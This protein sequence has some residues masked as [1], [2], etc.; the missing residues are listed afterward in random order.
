MKKNKKRIIIYTTRDEIFTLP[1][2]I[3]ICKDFH[4]KYFIDIYFGEA[5]LKRKLKVLL[6]FILFGS[7]SELTKLFKKRLKFNDIFK[8]KNVNLVKTC[9]K[10]YYYGLSFNYTEKIIIKNYKIFNFHLGNFSKQRGSFIFFYKFIYKWKTLDL[11]FHEINAQFDAGSILK[12]KIK[13]IAK[14]N[15]IQI[16]SLYLNDY[17]FVKKCLKIITKKNKKKSFLGKLNTEPSFF[18]IIK[19]FLISVKTAL[20]N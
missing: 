3:K 10:K 19:T 16:C 20:A 14:K 5:K 7:L 8:I 9:D 1:I 15:S 2:I 17:N 4:K 18:L 6:V 13:Y 12:K 11:T